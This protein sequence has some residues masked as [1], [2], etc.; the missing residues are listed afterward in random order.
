MTKINIK[1]L[2][3]QQK[4][5]LEKCNS[6]K[7]E[8]NL[9]K[10]VFNKGKKLKYCEILLIIYFETRTERDAWFGFGLD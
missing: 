6:L 9:E 4:I 5:Y 8:F 2:Y 7:K 10:M 3:K 1:P